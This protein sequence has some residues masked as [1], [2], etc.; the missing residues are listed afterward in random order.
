MSRILKYDIVTFTLSAI[1][2]FLASSGLFS[3]CFIFFQKTFSD[4]LQTIFVKDV[5]KQ[6]LKVTTKCVL[7]HIFA[8]YFPFKKDRENIDF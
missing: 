2:A 6:H 7:D 3:G 5:P 4:C 8:L 1:F